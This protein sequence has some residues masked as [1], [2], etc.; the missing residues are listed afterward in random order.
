[1]QLHCGDAQGGKVEGDVLLQE[2]RH[3]GD[4]IVLGGLYAVYCPWTFYMGMGICN[5]H[6]IQP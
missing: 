4:V 3:K 1:M 2:L 6:T 5:M